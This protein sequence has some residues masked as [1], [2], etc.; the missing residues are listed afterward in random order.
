M[1]AR[2][3]M[4]AVACRL[5]SQSPGGGWRD[6]ETGPMNSYKPEITVRT[7][8][9]TA[10]PEL[11]LPAFVLAQ[12]SQRSSKRAL[13]DAASGVAL[14]YA[15]LA[16]EVAKIST[17]LKAQGVTRG[18]VLA[19]CAPNSIEFVVTF[20]AA[21]SAGAVV[22]TVNPLWTEAEIC[23]QLRQ[24][25]ARYLVGTA[26]L[27][28]GKLRGPMRDTGVAKIF[29]IEGLGDGQMPRADEPAAGSNA[30][31]ASTEP[32]VDGQNAAEPALLLSS[33]G[34]TGLP[35][36]V[37]LTHRNLVASLCQTRLVHKVTAG[38]VVLAALP[39]FH[40]FALQVSLNLGL[41]EGATVVVLP[42]FELRSFLR[43]VEEHRVTRAEVVPPMVLG[44]ASSDLV[45]GHDLSSL[46]V[47]TSGAAPL[48]AELA[49]TCARRM[50]CRVKQ[51]YGLT[52]IGGAS[53]TAPDDGPEH[54]DSIGRA[55][56]GV[57]CRVIDPGSGDSASLDVPGEMLIRTPGNMQGYLGNPEATA[58][59]IDADGWLHTGDIVTVD[60]DG[61]YRVADRVKELIKYKGL[62]VAPAELEA[63]LLT[64]PAVADA[65][66]VRHPDDAA[67]EVPKAYVVRRDAVSERELMDWVA[68]QVAPYKQVRLVEF[69]DSIPRSPSGKIL[70]RLLI[71]HEVGGAVTFPAR[72]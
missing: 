35:K 71:A 31:S 42:R 67:G 46:R 14:T 66:V 10:I 59:T 24:V 7:G 41:L 62:S 44:L 17:G 55:L 53:H 70:R 57:E 40:I 1:P 19:L 51:M 18:E 45:A 26:D 43:A 25:G 37:V 2:R 33:S 36:I 16:G 23:R 8:E 27:L 58:A 15:E 72:P 12:A 69:T 64:H 4:Y 28:A 29:P 68:G 34:T 21:T 65:A 13:V 56:P 63:L 39:L 49:L 38:D 52:E 32:S 30:S 6:A 54:P 20:L 50:G 11:T 47:L 9:P 22:T 48:G 60:A 5:E 61:W 3:G